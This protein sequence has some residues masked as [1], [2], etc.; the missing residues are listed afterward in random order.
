MLQTINDVQTLP[1]IRRASAVERLPHQGTGEYEHCRSCPVTRIGS[2]LLSQIPL[3]LC[4]S[5]GILDPQ[6]YH[7]PCD[8]HIRD[9]VSERIRCIV[10][11]GQGASPATAS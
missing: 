11:I 9:E 7:D 10:P 8:Q 2:W 5:P 3:G 1:E 4:A 6:P